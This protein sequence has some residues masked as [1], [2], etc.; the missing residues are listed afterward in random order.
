MTTI[1]KFSDI[2]QPTISFANLTNR[3]FLNIF[4]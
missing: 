1:V 3:L 2:D 4:D